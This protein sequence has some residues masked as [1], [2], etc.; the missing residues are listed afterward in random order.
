MY[1]NPRLE[2][3]EKLHLY[4]RRQGYSLK[5]LL[6]EIVKRVPSLRN[7]L[8]ESD[9]QDMEIGELECDTAV[10][11]PYQPFALSKAEWCYVTRLRAGKTLEQVAKSTKLDVSELDYL[12]SGKG[13]V[14]MLVSFWEKRAEKSKKRAKARRAASAS[15]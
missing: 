13:D 2:A 10:L 6:K 12:E 5:Q 4:R 3:H 8:A 9:L 15:V 11:L 7:K 1:A 14:D